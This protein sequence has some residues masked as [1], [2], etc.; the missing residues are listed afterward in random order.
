MPRQTYPVRPSGSLWRGVVLK[1]GEI[2]VLPGEL[3]EGVNVFVDRGDTVEKRR[4]FIRGYPD[5]YNG[6]VVGLPWTRDPSV[7]KSYFLVDAGPTNAGVYSISGFVP[8]APPNLFPPPDGFPIDD[9]NRAD[10]EF[11]AATNDKWV[12]VQQGFQQN[13]GILS[14]E[15]RFVNGALTGTQTAFGGKAWFKPTPV[16]FV[17]IRTRAIKLGNHQVA[18]AEPTRT[19]FSARLGC[20]AHDSFHTVFDAG[21]NVASFY[22]GLLEHKRLTAGTSV[23]QLFLTKKIANATETTIANGGNI[24]VAAS[25]TPTNLELQFTRKAG[26][27]GQQELT[28]ALLN[29]AAIPPALLGGLTFVDSSPLPE[30]Q[31][32]SC[33]VVAVQRSP[34]AGSLSAGIVS[35]RWDDLLTEVAT[36]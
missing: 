5:A 2:L 18:F 9:Y 23:L 7:G 17:V 16:P 15:A 31:L 29:N 30:T 3:L 21:S 11:S 8:P 33:L 10:V 20:A 4:G 35:F 24:L 22:G 34:Q 32:D 28:M 12:A 13:F 14:N 27:P 25:D 19:V 6:P 26:N 1:S 36:D